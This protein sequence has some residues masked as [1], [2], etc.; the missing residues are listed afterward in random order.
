MQALDR[1]LHLAT[2]LRAAPRS[3]GGGYRLF[4]NPADFNGLQYLVRGIS[5]RDP[6]SHLFVSYLREGDNVLDVGANV[7]YH[8]VLASKIVGP[9]G[10]VFSFEA[11][12]MVGVQLKVTESN[13]NNNVRVFNLAV[14]DSLATLTFY[15]EIGGH[16]GRSSLL[17]HVA[18]ESQANQV[19]AIP[20]DSMLPDLP[21]ITLVKLDI[22]GAEMRALRGM[23]NLLSR[24]KPGVLLELTEQWL[25]ADGSSADELLAFMQQLGYTAHSIDS[26][27]AAFA[28]DP[29]RHQQD[30]LFLHADD[31]DRLRLLRQ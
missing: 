29:N 22:E 20:L 3:V 15:T 24:D 5:D 11:S 6:I 1:N 7:G 14:S 4:V 2:G 30:V 8:T 18:S 13:I 17:Q 23:R 9:R 16:T 25:R 21:N 10:K 28:R 19:P 26:G 31:H 27:H 12:P